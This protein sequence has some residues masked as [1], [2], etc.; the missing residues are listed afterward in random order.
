MQPVAVTPDREVPA[1]YV[2]P[3]EPKYYCL[4]WNRKRL[5]YCR[6]R[7]GARTGHV[8]VGR[9]WVHDGG[10]ETRVKHGLLRRPY[11]LRTPRL[12]ELI[13]I[14]AADPAPLDLSTELAL[15]RA[16]LQDWLD[17]DDGDPRDGMKLVEKVTQIVE[18]IEGI[19]SKNYITFGQLKRFL[20]MVKRVL[21]LRV[22]DEAVRTQ[23]FADLVS[24][25]IPY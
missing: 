11:Q 21:E 19:N 14:H 25:R 12:S 1:T 8:G 7:A 4:A 6:S 3:L 13:E 10:G 16:L 2:G 22:P 5:K 9:C 20:F 15:A 23:I 18:R 24:L 17:R